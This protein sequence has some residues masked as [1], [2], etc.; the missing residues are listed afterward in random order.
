MGIGLVLGLGVVNDIVP[1]PVGTL[2][3]INCA[4]VISRIYSQSIAQGSVHYIEHFTEH[5]ADRSR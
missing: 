1:V 2:L 5:A 4:G 3:V